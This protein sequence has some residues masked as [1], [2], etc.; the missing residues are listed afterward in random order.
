MKFIFKDTSILLAAE[1]FAKYPHCSGIRQW[2]NG[3]AGNNS[4]VPYNINFPNILLI[5]WGFDVGA[6]ITSMQFVGVNL[7][8][9]NKN[10]F[11]LYTSNGGNI[12]LGYV[13]I[14]Y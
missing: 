4:D 9:S 11:R 14:G 8:Q 12:G 1:L 7:Q 3:N 10:T 6:Q 2:G 5:V 13:A